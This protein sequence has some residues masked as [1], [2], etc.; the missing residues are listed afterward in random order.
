M[1]N[2][3]ERI[4]AVR[5]EDEHQMI[6]DKLDDMLDSTEA[7]ISPSFARRNILHYLKTIRFKGLIKERSMYLVYS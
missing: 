2:N 5:A 6:F 3:N 1:V 4:A 7:L